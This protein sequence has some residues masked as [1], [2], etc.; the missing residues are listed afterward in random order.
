[1]LLFPLVAVQERLFLLH[2]IGTNEQL[3]LP[4]HIDIQERPVLF[5]ESLDPA[6]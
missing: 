4:P 2:S 6:V 5:H 3:L 1:M